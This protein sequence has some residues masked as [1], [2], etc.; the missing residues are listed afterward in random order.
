MNCFANDPRCVVVE[1]E[2]NTIRDLDEFRRAVAFK[3]GEVKRAP[4]R[5]NGANRDAARIMD[6]FAQLFDE[7][8]D[9]I[10]SRPHELPQLWLLKERAR[11]ILPT[12]PAFLLARHEEAVERRLD[13]ICDA[14]HVHTTAR[15]IFTRAG[16]EI[17]SEQHLHEGVESDANELVMVVM[18]KGQV[19]NG[20]ELYHVWLIIDGDVHQKRLQELAH[21]GMGWAQREGERLAVHRLLRKVWVSRS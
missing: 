1:G 3:P 10:D 6:G 9:D 20:L 16:M 4:P 15:H 14:L 7:I 12:D 2:R 5:N 13:K 21:L 8:G 11:E 19:L 17:E 18:H